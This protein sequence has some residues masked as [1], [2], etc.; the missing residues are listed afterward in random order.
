MNLGRGRDRASDD[1]EEG[2]EEEKKGP[3]I[4]KFGLKIWSNF[5]RDSISKKGHKD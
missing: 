2:E 4:S 5:V 3:P 1:S